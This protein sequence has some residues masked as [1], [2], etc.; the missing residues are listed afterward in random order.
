MYTEIRKSVLAMSFLIREQMSLRNG[1]ERERAG[2][3][4]ERDIV[5]ECIHVLNARKI[6]ATD[7]DGK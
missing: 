6:H 1:R 5:D 7:D 2:I 3:E 4:G